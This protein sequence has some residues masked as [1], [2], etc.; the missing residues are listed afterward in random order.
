MPPLVGHKSHTKKAEWGIPQ[1]SVMKGTS[2]LHDT[3]SAHAQ[4][5]PALSRPARLR[6]PPG[7]KL[8]TVP[9]V[10]AYPGGHILIKF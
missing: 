8:G 9:S 5:D 4:D 1:Q 2:L 10:G 6:R 3:A 7:S